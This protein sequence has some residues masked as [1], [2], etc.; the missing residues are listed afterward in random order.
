MTNRNEDK[1]LLLHRLV[2]I[3]ENLFTGVH[4]QIPSE[5]SMLYGYLNS[6]DHLLY[7][8]LVRCIT[9]LNRP[10]RM[11]EGDRLLS[12][13]D[14]L[15]NALHLLLPRNEQLTPK[16]L[17]SYDVLRSFYKESWFNYHQAASRL[18]VSERTVHRMIKVMLLYGLLERDTEAFNKRA[19]FRVPVD[20]NDSALSMF[21]EANEDWEDFIGFVE[22]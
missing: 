3:V 21:S 15:L 10:S 18:Q 5:I 16:I 12:S 6:E 1:K 19:K 9:L 2:M 11:Q 13:Q 20:P 22:F 4:T 8:S 17:D 7:E 14:D